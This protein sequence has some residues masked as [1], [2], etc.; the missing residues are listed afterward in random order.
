MTIEYVGGCQCDHIRY[1]LTGKPYAIYTCHCHRCQKQSGSAFG[2]AAVFVE[3]NMTITDGS[4]NHFVRE[5]EGRDLKC[6]FCPKCGSRIYHQYFNKDGDLP[7]L[8][9]KPGTLDDTSWIVPGS[10]LWM[11]SAQGW[12]A[13]HEGDILFDEQTTEL[14]PF[15]PE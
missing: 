7:F 8:N 2:L 11:S 4:L 5:G 15:V 12:E 3:A 6:Y 14:P 1:V 9:L 10:H 13:F